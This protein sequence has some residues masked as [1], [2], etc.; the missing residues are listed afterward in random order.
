MMNPRKQLRKA[1]QLAKRDHDMSG[2]GSF[3]FQN[4]TA[5]SYQLPRP[6]ASNVRNIPHKGQFVGDDY[7]MQLVQSGELRLVKK[8]AENDGTVLTE[9]TFVFKNRTLDNLYLNDGKA[10]PVGGEFTG[11]AQY[12]PMIQTGQLLLVSEVKAMEEKLITEQ[13][14]LITTEGQVEFVMRNDKLNEEDA[15]DKKKKKLNENPLEGVRLLLD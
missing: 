7:Y 9:Q 6:T 8:L 1:Q 13:P 2:A 5:G 15:K 3:L 14:P 12:L 11:N 10:I 4:N